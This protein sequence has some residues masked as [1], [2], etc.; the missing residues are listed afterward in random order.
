MKLVTF[1]LAAT[2]IT[3]AFGE[4]TVSE[5]FCPSSDGFVTI[6]NGILEASQT[7]INYAWPTL[8]DTFNI[9]PLSIETSL[10][11]ADV[12][13]P[14]STSVFKFTCNSIF[15]SVAKVSFSVRNPTVSGFSAFKLD[16]I[17][18]D[19]T[20]EGTG[21]SCKN[22]SKSGPFRCAY[23]GL[24][25]IDAVVEGGLSIDIEIGTDVNCQPCDK[26]DWFGNCVKQGTAY[27]KDAGRTI[28]CT[29]PEGIAL[30]GSY[31]TG[32]CSAFPWTP[33]VNSINIDDVKLMS[34]MECD[35]GDDVLAAVFETV[36]PI[37]M[38]TKT[39]VSAIK[40]PLNE[41]IG[42]NFPSPYGCGSD[43]AKPEY[44]R[45]VVA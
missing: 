26:R 32:Q 14:I 6:L 4:D 9:D 5:D 42:A 29:L 25:D 20:D 15:E 37:D 10:S 45:N 11:L 33:V 23:E 36:L 43:D 13:D 2:T 41:V 21:S 39:M 35:F 30:D 27:V 12:D 40:A 3:S 44:L 1:L 34:E 28:S 24:L 17:N 22:D 19:S 7:A 18:I 16:K 38:I 8:V 31:C